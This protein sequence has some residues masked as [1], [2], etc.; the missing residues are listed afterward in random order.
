[1]KEEMKQHMASAGKE[2]EQLFSETDNKM[3]SGG[4]KE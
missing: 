2:N 1:M 4:S 3:S